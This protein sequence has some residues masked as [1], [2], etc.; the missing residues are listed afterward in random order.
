MSD[1]IRAI[2]DLVRRESAFIDAISTK[3]ERSSSVRKA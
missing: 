2:N 1:D 3:L